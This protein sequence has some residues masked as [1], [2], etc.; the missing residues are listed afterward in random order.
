MRKCIH[1]AVFVALACVASASARADEGGGTN[2]V[3]EKAV[4]ALG[5]EQRLSKFKAATWKA[6]GKIRI[7]GKEH[8]F[9]SD[10]AVQG[11]D[12]YRE[13]FYTEFLDRKVKSVAVLYGDKGYR[14]VAD[15][16]T[17]LDQQG[18]ADLKRTVYLLVIPATIV[19]L[20]AK[21]Y[22]LQAL[23]EQEIGDRIAVGIKVTGPDKKDFRIYFDKESGLPVKLVANVVAIGGGEFTDET[24]YANYKDFGGIMKATKITIKRD[25]KRFMEQEITDFKMVEKLDDKA[26]L[27]PD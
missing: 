6:R 7:E 21:G 23:P 4:S 18:V 9:S 14:H 1:P 20:R 10:S 16:A 24:T 12:Q 27:K 15:V 17:E 13:E 19:P 3:L 26:F 22:K 2:A 11:L 5:G 25:G 8:D